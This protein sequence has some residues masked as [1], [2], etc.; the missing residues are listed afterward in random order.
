MTAFS[1]DHYYL[2]FTC[3]CHRRGCIVAKGLKGLA[4]TFRDVLNGGH[5]HVMPL[6][7]FLA[8]EVPAPAWYQ[9]ER[10]YAENIQRNQQAIYDALTEFYSADMDEDV[11]KRLGLLNI[12]PKCEGDRFRFTEVCDVCFDT[13]IVPAK[14]TWEEIHERRKVLGPIDE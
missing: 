8:R 6:K 10:E 9:V 13:G 3:G 2:S 14:F 1:D 5:Q 7:L 4:A 12:C 11:A